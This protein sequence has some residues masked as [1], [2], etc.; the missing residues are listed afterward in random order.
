MKRDLSIALITILLSYA[1]GHAIVVVYQDGVVSI[2][3]Q[4]AVGYIINVEQRGRIFP[5]YD[6]YLLHAVD[7]LGESES[8]RY[9]L[10][11]KDAAKLA[12]MAQL[13]EDLSIRVRLTYTTE[14][15]GTCYASLLV[16]V[17]DCDVVTNITPIK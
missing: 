16:R 8:E 12:A 14:S 10:D 9:S 4:Q 13:V 5:T 7:G 11:Y 3:N 2:T 15:F 17:N 1:I 6:I